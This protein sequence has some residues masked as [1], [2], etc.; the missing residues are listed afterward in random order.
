MPVSIPISITDANLASL[1]SGIQTSDP[2]TTPDHQLIST[3]E[4]L[5]MR[6]AVMHITS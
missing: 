3:V 6:K 5:A 1:S 2:S 4:Y